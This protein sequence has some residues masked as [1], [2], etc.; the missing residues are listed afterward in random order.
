MSTSRRQS[1]SAKS[2]TPS[3]VNVI[4]RFRPTKQ[5][6]SNNSN[7]EESEIDWFNVNKNEDS[8]EITDPRTGN[9]LFFSYDKVFI[10]TAEQVDVFNSLSH[11]VEGCLNGFNG[12]ILAY[13][14][15]SSGKTH[16]MV[17]YEKNLLTVSNSSDSSMDVHSKGYH[18]NS[19]DEVK[20]F[21]GIIPRSINYIFDDIRKNS[22]HTEYFLTISY[23]E[24]YC[25]K[26]RDLISGHK[27]GITQVNSRRIQN[28]DPNDLKFIESEKG[29]ISLNGVT[30]VPVQDKKDILQ[31]LDF[32][33][34]QRA[35]SSTLMNATSSRSHAIFTININSKNKNS[36]SIKRAKLVLV[37]LAGSEKI[38]KTGAV[39]LRLDEAKKINLSLTVL[40]MVIKALSEGNN[41][42]PYRDSKLT[43]MLEESLGGN[44]RTCLVTCVAPEALH[45][46]ETVSTLRFGERAKLV[47][48]YAKVNEEL[49]MEELKKLVKKLK[50]ENETLRKQLQAFNDDTIIPEPT[51]HK[52]QAKK[53]DEGEQKYD[54]SPSSPSY[55]N[56]SLNEEDSDTDF[57]ILKK[58]VQNLKRHLELERKERFSLESQMM[59]LCQYEEQIQTLKS[60]NLELERMLAEEINEKEKLS[61]DII[62]LEERARKAETNL[63]GLLSL[64]KEVSV[65]RRS[66]D[67]A[68]SLN[69]SMLKTYNFE[70]SH[71]IDF[72]G[73]LQF[74]KDM[75]KTNNEIETTTNELSS[76]SPSTASGLSYTTENDFPTSDTKY[77][78]SERELELERKI[79][80]L[81]EELAAQ[82]ETFHVIGEK[83]N[84]IMRRLL[85]R[86]TELVVDKD[87]MCRENFELESK[88]A[89]VST[90][91]ERYQVSEEETAKSKSGRRK[92][93]FDIIYN[94]VQIPSWLGGD[95]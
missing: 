28:I 9:K 21:E 78:K 14:Q 60:N 31:V 81:E 4:V 67:Y 90:I 83:N 49:G 77:I 47:K 92:S 2:A 32:G 3:S 27:K 71:D 79:K 85:E 34:I 18:D 46:A 1:I 35:T 26:I 82:T 40:G 55:V 6:S 51:L 59:R 16:T 23:V 54:D 7:N 33:N 53:D 25:E 19:K 29:I 76:P 20:D 94:S 56:D 22:E 65:V 5:T 88:L 84:E 80:A 52:K 10:G 11:V 57:T 44:S 95:M 74:D 43:R 41:H 73:S 61:E 87:K 24:L 70:D 30:E 50:K 8:V 64:K 91:L 45:S 62:E 36:G 17:G 13:G 38:S 63:E 89:D 66:I 37:D 58:D 15:T 86:T 75:N 39:G 42:V 12:T 72:S 93:A 48:T 68:N 69:L